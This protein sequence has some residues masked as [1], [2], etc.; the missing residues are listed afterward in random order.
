MA[1]LEIWDGQTKIPLTIIA[2]APEGSRPWCLGYD[3]QGRLYSPVRESSGPGGS[4]LQERRTYK[5]TGSTDQS[6]V[7][8]PNQEVVVSQWEE[9]TALVPQ[10]SHIESL[11]KETIEEIFQTQVINGYVDAPAFG[12]WKFKNT[13]QKKPSIDTL[14][15]VPKLVIGG[16]RLLYLPTDTKLQDKSSVWYVT[17]GLQYPAHGTQRSNV[18]TPRFPIVVMGIQYE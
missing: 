11:S 18:N 17:L 1:L 4:P 5:F 3:G 2:V 16:H 13:E 6:L 15:G 8:F 9:D 14:E 10:P 12:V 7:R